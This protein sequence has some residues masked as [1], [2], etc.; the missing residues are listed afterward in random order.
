LLGCSGGSRKERTPSECDSL[1]LSAAKE[2]AKKHKH[3]D[4]DDDDPRIRLTAK[5][6]PSVASI[7]ASK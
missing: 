1:R 6:I 7:R 2:K 5:S 4:D 3:N